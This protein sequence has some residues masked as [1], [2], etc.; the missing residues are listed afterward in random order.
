MVL[1]TASEAK[2]KFLRLLRESHEFGERY[3]IT[4]N[5]KP[6]AVL[7]SSDEYEGLI[8]T[9]EILQ[10][11]TLT[12]ELLESMQRADQKNTLSFEDVTGQ[13]QK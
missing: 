2:E 12:K 6:Y 1:L 11:K 7:L 13:K 8:E 5:G 4:R 9:L 3:T 10:N